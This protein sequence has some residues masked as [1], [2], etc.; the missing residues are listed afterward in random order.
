MI[1]SVNETPPKLKPADVAITVWRDMYRGVVINISA[2]NGYYV[3]APG[4]ESKRGWPTNRALD[5]IKAIQRLDH[6]G[7]QRAL[8]FDGP[9][10]LPKRTHIIVEPECFDWFREDRSQQNR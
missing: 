8:G 7:L 6:Q 3:D 9:Y 1:M 10:F 5:A 4:D 2:S